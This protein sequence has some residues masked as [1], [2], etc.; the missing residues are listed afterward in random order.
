MFVT[1]EIV[2]LAKEIFDEVI[3]ELDVVTE[4]VAG[5]HR[6]A[7]DLLGMLRIDEANER[8][9]LDVRIGASCMF[10]QHGLFLSLECTCGNLTP[11]DEKSNLCFLF[12][13]SVRIDESCRVSVCALLVQ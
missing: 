8:Y 5:D 3:L 9:E 12:I 10:D 1:P 4:L 6:Y 2:G 11:Y 13:V 7:V